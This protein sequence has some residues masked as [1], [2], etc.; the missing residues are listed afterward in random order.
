MDIYKDFPE[1]RRKTAAKLRGE[2]AAV[3]DEQALLER[4]FAEIGHAEKLCGLFDQWKAEENELYDRDKKMREEAG[5]EPHGMLILASEVD[6]FN[7]WDGR[8]EKEEADYESIRKE[9]GEGNLPYVL[10]MLY[11]GADLAHGS[12]FLPKE[13]DPGYK[14]S[15]CR[16]LQTNQDDFVLYADPHYMVKEKTPGVLGE[17]LRSGMEVVKKA[18][19]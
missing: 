4:C 11:A 7:L 17:W 8:A 12:W 10:M 18:A 9:I 16:L 13:N 3:L 5:M 19:A 6:V 1:E 15:V 14:D 2:D